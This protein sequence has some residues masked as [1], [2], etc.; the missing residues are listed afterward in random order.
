M[1][2]DWQCRSTGPYEL[3]WESPGAEWSLDR[4]R[5]RPA[6]GQ[7]QRSDSAVGR[8]HWANR[9][10]LRV[11]QSTGD[12]LIWECHRVGLCS[13]S[14]P[15]A[16]LCHC[17]PS[18]IPGYKLNLFASRY[19]HHD[20]S[21]L[22]PASIDWDL[23]KTMSQMKPP[24]LLGIDFCVSVMGRWLIQTPCETN[25]KASESSRW[26]VTVNLYC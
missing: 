25:S 9:T 21:A 10:E 13:E 12:S 15:S 16:F 5:E 18:L 3:T 7:K 26:S 2:G 6:C 4:K 23:L 22:K 11:A 8:L 20:V 14:G 1:A 17:S 24:I 19:F